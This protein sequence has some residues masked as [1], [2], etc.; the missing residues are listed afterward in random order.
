MIAAAHMSMILALGLVAGIPL[1]AAFGLGALERKCHRFVQ[2]LGEKLNRSERPL[3]T[4]AMRGF[5]VPALC[6]VLA[7][8]VGFL[9]SFLIVKFFPSTDA[10]KYVVILVAAALLSPMRYLWPCVQALRTNA[11][12]DPS[13]L[14]APLR[15]LAGGDASANDA[16]GKIRLML[17]MALQHFVQH[18]VGSIMAF[19]L[20]GFAGLFMFRMALLCAEHFDGRVQ[21]MRGFHWASEK[22]GQALRFIA[23]LPALPL[24]VLA[25]Q[26][27]PQLA[28]LRGLWRARQLH[29]QSFLVNFLAGSLRI[30]LGGPMQRYGQ[31]FITPW[32]GDGTA[33]LSASHVLRVLWWL[34]VAWVLLTILVAFM[35]GEQSLSFYFSIYFGK[36][37]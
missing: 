21:K 5:I 35:A 6:I 1:R 11:T 22:L 33:Q 10:R 18:G 2:R 16:H 9:L 7:W 36:I 15:A 28:P 30:S 8:L 25:G 19:W 31:R 14:D 26:C 27:L 3:S 23:L 24:L 37:L 29:G 20:G 4:R 12:Q 32:V 13:T 34:L 17:Q